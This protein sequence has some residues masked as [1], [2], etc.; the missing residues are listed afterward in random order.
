M[1]LYLFKAKMAQIFRLH[2]GD[3]LELDGD[4]LIGQVSGVPFRAAKFSRT[5]AAR[6]R[7]L[8]R[9]GYRPNSA[10]V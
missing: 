10:N 4:Y 1:V 7:D 5:C 8:R 9:K 2:S 6:I 3:S